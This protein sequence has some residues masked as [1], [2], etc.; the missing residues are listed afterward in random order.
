M[1]TIIE[2]ALFLQDIDIFKYTLT[3]DL[4]HIAE[5]TKEIEYKPDEIIFNEGE[6]PDA[7]YMVIEGRV[8]LTRGDQEVMTADKKDVFGT[9]A[10]FD[11]E[12]RVAT[13][14]SLIETQLLRIDKE[15]FVDLLA[16]H[17]R[18]TQSILKTVVKRLRNLMERLNI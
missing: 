9:W 18:I 5:I 6:I 10:L 11:D 1:L 2:K 12:P 15:D 4:A 16:D 17:V 7:M 14:T 8:R 13:A 3:E